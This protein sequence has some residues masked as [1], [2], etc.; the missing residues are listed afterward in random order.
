MKSG[1]DLNA[2]RRGGTAGGNQ[3]YEG[4][5]SESIRSS[6]GTVFHR[7]GR[8]Q[9]ADAGDDDASDGQ[10]NADAESRDDHVGLSVVAVLERVIPLIKHLHHRRAEADGHDDGDGEAAHAHSRRSVA[11]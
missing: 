2:Q 1:D 6:E 9:S 3:A 8:R 5:R 4:A 11:L 10:R 7:A